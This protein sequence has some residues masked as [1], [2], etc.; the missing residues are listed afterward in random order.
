MRK[1]LLLIFGLIIWQCAFAKN[2]TGKVVAADTKEELIGVTVLVKGTTIGT[3]TDINGQYN[4]NVPDEYNILTFTYIGYNVDEITIDGRTFIDIQLLPSIEELEGVVVTALGIKR[5]EKALGYAVQ[6]VDGELVSDVKEPDVMN[7]LAGKVSG[8]SVIQADGA[9][10]GGGSRVVIRGESSLAGNNDPLYIINGVQGEANDIAPDDIESI[11]VLKGPAAAALYGSKAGGGVIIITSKSG[12][13]KNGFEVAINSSSMFQTPLVLPEYQNRYG[14]GYSGE[15]SYYDGTSGA[16]S[17]YNDDVDYCWGPELDGGIRSQ[18]TGDNPWIAY[19]D[20]VKDFYEV[21]HILTNSVSVSNSSDK[22]SFRFAYTNVDQKGIMPNNGMSKNT[23]AFNGNYTPIEGLTITPNMSY[24]STVCDNS[25]TVDVRFIPR[26]IDFSALEDYWV[27]GMEGEQQMNYRRSANNPY[28]VLYECPYSYKDSKIIANVAVNYEFLK[29]WSAMGRVGVDFTNNVWEDKR[30]KSTY[31]S[32]NL[33]LNGYYATGY[34]NTWNKSADFLLAYEKTF[35]DNLNAKLSY[36]GSH[37]RVDYKTLSGNTYELTYTGIYNLN[38]R[39]GYL[40][41]LNDY[42]SNKEENSLY[43]FLNLDYKGK[44]FLDITNR[45]D[46]SSTLNPDNN[47]F[48]YQSA[49][50]AAI[51]SDIVTLPNAISFLKIRGSVAAVGNSIPQPYFTVEE[52]YEYNALNGLSTIEVQDVQTDPDLEPER[53]TGYEVGLDLRLLN[54]RLNIDAAA[55]YSTTTNQILNTEKSTT[56]GGETSI[57]INAG[58]V[59]SKGL[60]I[61]LNAIPVKT[62]DFTWDV[63]LNWSIDRTIIKELLEDDPDYEN[64]QNVNSFLSIVDKKGKRRGEFYGKAYQ[65]D[66]NG[67]RIYTASGDTQLT[68]GEV[69]LGNYNPDWIGS[70]NNTFTYKNLSLSCLLDLRWGGLIYNEI[71]RRLNMKGFSKATLLNNRE[72]IVPNGV[73]DNGD[74]TYSKLTLEI[75][76]NAGASGQ[77]GQEYWENQMEEAC[78]ENVLVDDTYLKLRELRI[79]YN[80]PQSLLGNTFIKSLSIAAVG[81]NLAVWSKVKHIDPE[82]YGV[83]SETNVFGGSTKVPG[84]ATSSVPSV[85]S[86]GFTLSCKF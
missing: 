28:F 27:K 84:Y 48:S 79:G 9:I 34:S 38:N 66:P 36:G 47:H 29:H 83:A 41:Y 75:L 44:L 73:V 86:Y 11:S 59:D 5:S 1:L 25:R 14:M 68:S 3:I 18:F 53:T 32:D 42:K 76:E 39:D 51:L 50:F 19:E 80:V 52:K 55:Y 35:F 31:T 22:G 10:G 67:N 12:T 30:A 26:N 65:R 60:E 69:A 82:T 74:G 4:L 15:Y 17:E 23:F 6:K 20:N 81:R 40:N 62:R 57:N 85:R 7:A 37:Y 33:E 2:I 70:M 61:T 16:G 54:N 71:E 64:V 45:D 24:I 78:P 58:R 46:W 63:T 56:S 21:G 72:D 49:T 77:S 8:V 13:K 43:G